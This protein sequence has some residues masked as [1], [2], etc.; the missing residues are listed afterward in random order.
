MLC[1]M[2]F[3]LMV[4]APIMCV[5]GVIMA[6]NEDVPL[7][8]LLLLIVPALGLVVALIVRRMRPL[9]RDVQQRIDTVN[10]VLREQITGIRVIRAFVRDT[11]S[12]AASPAPTPG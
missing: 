1:L 8:G 9:F 5:G 12:A 3:T 10:R 7:S 11:Q 6:L 2:A 4:S